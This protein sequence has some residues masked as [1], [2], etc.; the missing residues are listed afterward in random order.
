MT[1]LMV[2]VIIMVMVTVMMVM[3]RAEQLHSMGYLSL[4]ACKAAFTVSASTS[5]AVPTAC[6]QQ[7]TLAVMLQ[8]TYHGSQDAV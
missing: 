8:Y 5:V 2:L 6:M 1:I 3:I 4:C 7:S